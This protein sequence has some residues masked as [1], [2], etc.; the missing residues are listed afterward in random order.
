MGLFKITLGLLSSLIR[1]V[2]H[3]EVEKID[4][5]LLQFRQL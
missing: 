4:S 1:E 5:F 3:Q 2:F